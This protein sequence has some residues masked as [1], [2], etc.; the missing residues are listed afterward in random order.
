MSKLRGDYITIQPLSWRGAFGFRPP[1]VGHPGR[2]GKPVHGPAA[3]QR[4]FFRGRCAGGWGDVTHY[5][6]RERCNCSSAGV[7][8]RRIEVIMGREPSGHS[9]IENEV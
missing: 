5:G 9:C 2:K 3:C 8:P 1:S 7:D 4:Q 6:S